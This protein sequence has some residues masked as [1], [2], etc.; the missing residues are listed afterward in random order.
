[1]PTALASTRRRLF[2]AYQHR[3]R[4]FAGGRYAEYV[5]PTWISFLLTER[6][7]ARCVH[8]DIWKNRGKEDSPTGEQWMAALD[9]LRD[10]LGPAHVC[11]TGGEALLKKFTIDVVEHGSRRGLLMEVL[12]HGYWKDQNRI[13]ALARAQPWRVTLSLDG[14]GETHDLVRGRQGFFDRTAMTIDTLKRIR[15]QEGLGFTIRLKT[16]IMSQNLQGLQELAEFATQPGVDILYQAIEQNYARAPDPDWYHHS[17]NWPD[18]PE[19]AVT[20]VRQLIDLKDQGLNIANGRR[21][22]EHM[23][24][25]F[26]DPA[27]LESHDWGGRCSAL[28][29]FQVQSNGD[30]KVCWKA[31]PV[32]NIKE[33]RPRDIWAQRPHLWKAGCCHHVE[34]TDTGIPA[35]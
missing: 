25:Y 12:T 6:C 3:L 26:R 23:I 20:A 17:E 34:V 4:D 15:A 21:Q 7:N 27:G 5:R 8:C 30:V 11:L 2:E 24:E 14:L 18:D 28:E 32:G 31:S 10:W 22:L 9:D 19:E 29:L 13:E 35:D 33:A 1:M 16:V